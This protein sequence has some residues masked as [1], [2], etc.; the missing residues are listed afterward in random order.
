MSFNKV[1]AA[2][3]S[4][5]NTPHTLQVIAVLDWAWQS[6]LSP[7]IVLDLHSI[8]QFDDKRKFKAVLEHTD[9]QTRA[10]LLDD[11]KPSGWRVEKD[12]IHFDHLKELSPGVEIIIPVMFIESVI[13][14]GLMEIMIPI[15]TMVDLAVFQ[16][17][18]QGGVSPAVLAKVAGPNV[19]PKPTLTLVK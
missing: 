15:A 12:L 16:N 19:P 11:T 7:A 2:L 4:Q 3:E 8:D 14:P 9:R 5:N 17:R 13:I 18:H 1:M 10:W 6:G